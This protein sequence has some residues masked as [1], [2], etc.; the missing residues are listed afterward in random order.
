MS[1]PV[2]VKWF[3]SDMLGAPALS[4]TAGALIAVLDACLVNGFGSV[5]L[6]SLTVSDGVATAIKSGHGFPDHAVV[7][8]NESTPS[9]LNG[10]KRITQIDANT[11]TFDATGISDQTATGTITA[12]IAPLGFSKAY[13]GTNKAVYRGE[14][15][16]GN[17]LY[18]RV[19]DEG[20]GA[21][22]YSRVRGYESMSDVDTGTGP[23]PTDA[24]ISG[25][26]Y[27]GKSTTANSTARS[28]R[29]FGDSQG[30][31]YFSDSSG[32]GQWA[33]GTWIGINSD[34]V[35][36]EFATLIIGGDSSGVANACLIANM[37]NRVGHYMPRTYTQLGTAI[38]VI[39]I[40]NQI[41]SS[42]SGAAGLPYPSPGT[43]KLY[44][45]PI[46]I[47][48]GTSSAAVT[49]LR[50]SFPGVY[51]ILHVGSQVT[52][53]EQHV[54]LSGLDD[55]VMMMQ[56]IYYAGYSLAVLID[57]TGTWR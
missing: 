10:E 16:A 4:G 13:S 27:W 14:D 53:G 32:A 8:I 18:L 1:N 17:R 56:R 46:D 21:A 29:L 36:D 19:A 57:I 45:A 12:K 15:I 55:R 25:G 44:C 31:Y 35:G 30:F 54:G 22:T 33:G 49:A 39:K 5:T 51:A 38:Q 28:W 2:D 43:G 9:G 20:A 34:H 26:L 24:Q 41:V 50:G 23:F 37:S 40:T 48:E 6:T 7:L 11:F 3:T 42:Y 47:F 52:D